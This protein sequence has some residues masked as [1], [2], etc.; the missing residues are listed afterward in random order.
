VPF[1][2]EQRAIAR[3]LDDI[4]ARMTTAMERAAAAQAAAEGNMTA[5]LAAAINSAQEIG[6]LQAQH[7]NLF[8]ALLVALSK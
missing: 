6:A 5:A 1:N 3:R 4:S 2:P 7:G 8:R